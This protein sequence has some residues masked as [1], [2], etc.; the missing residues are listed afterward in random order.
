VSGVRGLIW[1][2][3]ALL[4]GYVA[5]QLY[6]ASRPGAPGAGGPAAPAPAKSDASEDV[7][8]EDAEDEIFVFERP[9]VAPAAIA[10]QPAKPGEDRFQLELEVQQLRRDLA[11]LRAEFADQRRELSELGASVNAQRDQLEAGLA[12]QGVSPEYN[13][14]LVFARRGLGV[15]A[16]AE[17]CGITLAEAELVVSLARREEDQ[18]GA[19]A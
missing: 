6:R 16:I 10:A 17:R 12:N 15:E 1:L 19:Q 7:A 4:L 5:Y 18:P 8:A 9:T 14:A 13:E 2:L 3:I 11:Q